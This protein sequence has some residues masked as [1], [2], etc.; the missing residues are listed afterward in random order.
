MTNKEFEQ[1]TKLVNAAINTYFMPSYENISRISTEIEKTKI[2]HSNIPNRE[3]EIIK[4]WQ[5]LGHGLFT[6]H[7]YDIARI[8]YGKING[9][10]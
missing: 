3:K 8:I 2:E 6:I 7:N 10:P 1:R 9:L 4:A 5:D